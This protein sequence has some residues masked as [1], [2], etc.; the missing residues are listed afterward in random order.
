[1]SVLIKTLNRDLIRNHAKIVILIWILQIL[2]PVS[3]VMFTLFLF[4]GSFTLIDLGLS[5]A[6]GL[7]TD[8]FLSIM[9]FLQ[10]SIMVRSGFK[11]WL[12]KYMP[13]IYHNAFYGITSAIALLL[14]MTFWQKSATL[15]ANADGIIFWILRALFFLCLAGFFWG[16]K[17]LGSFDALGVKPLMRYISNRQCKPQKIVAKG[18]YRWSRHPLYLFV[19]ILIWSC[20]V[21]TLDRLI[22]NMMW[23]IWIIV[24]TF[25]EDRDLHR[26][27]GSQY[28]EYSSKVPMLIPYRIPGNKPV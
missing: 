8:I 19:I 25:L 23:T 13:D 16:S 14:V 1:M 6:D 28:R 17:S 26:E 15:V 7:L 9:F 27:F 10:H 2:G 3:G 18:P 20:P 4:W 24:G 5:S 12:G 22:F 11:Q 21:L